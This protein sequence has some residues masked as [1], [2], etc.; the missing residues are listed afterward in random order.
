MIIRWISDV[1][2]KIVK[3]LEAR[4][5]SSAYPRGPPPAPADGVPLS[6]QCRARVSGR[7]GPRAVQAD[8]H[9]ADNHGPA[10]NYTVLRNLHYSVSQRFAA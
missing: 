2:S 5:E 4:E 7:T 8:L 1:P 6:F 3:I 9:R 10:G